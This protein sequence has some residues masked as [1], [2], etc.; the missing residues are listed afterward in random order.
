MAIIGCGLASEAYCTVIPL[1]NEV[2]S[3][4]HKRANGITIN[5]LPL[6][7]PL[8]SGF[9]VSVTNIDLATTQGINSTVFNLPKGELYLLPLS[10]SANLK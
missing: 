7:A 3:T 9:S 5:N 6:K 1:A 4:I 8:C 2:P 10:G